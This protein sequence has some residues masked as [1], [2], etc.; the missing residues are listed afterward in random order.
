M[1]ALRHLGT[2]DMV[3]VIVHRLPATEYP[4]QSFPSR[5]ARLIDHERREQFAAQNY[6]RTLRRIYFTTQMEAAVPSHVRSA[7]FS[8]GHWN[9]KAD[10]ILQRF[11]ERQANVLDALGGTIP[12]RRLTPT[13]TFRDLILAVTGRDYPAIMPSG[14]VRLNEIIASERWYGGVAPWIGELHLRPVCITAYPAET[15]P[16]MLAVLLRH[17]GQMT[18][19]ARFI[20]QDPHDA[21][22]QLQLER[23][24][25][26]RAQLG[27][28]IDIIARA[29]NIP[30]RKSV[31][32]DAEQQIAEVDEAIAAAAAGMPFGWG[33]IIAE[34]K[35][36]ESE[37]ATM[38]ARA[39]VKDLSAIGVTAR[40]EDA[41]AVEA[42]QGGWP[43]NGW[44]NVRR[45]ADYRREFRGDD[46]AGGTL[47]GHADH[48]LALLSAG[49]PRA[50]SLWRQRQGALLSAVTCRRCG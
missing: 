2:N 48:R 15:V 46:S 34:I 32:Q 35:D 26:V 27:S 17:P 3:Q 20:C 4:E 41:N 16:Q 33:T 42:I 18:L 10:L 36:Y 45:P 12:L 49:N 44:S 22:E 5:A 29:L 31:N 23:T 11:R 13:E 40:L 9:P 6:W 39:L 24:F 25:W 37:L 21:H 7:V 43:G 30:R 38:R 50:V 14:K 47:A 19:S 28:F 8:A 1:E